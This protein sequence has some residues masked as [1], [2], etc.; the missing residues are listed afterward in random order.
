[1]QR[2]RELVGQSSGRLEAGKE[3]DEN[4]WGGSIEM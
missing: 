2:K 1:M 3:I 4:V